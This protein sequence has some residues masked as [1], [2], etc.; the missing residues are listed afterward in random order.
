[1][2]YLEYSFLATA[3]NLADNS[4]SGPIQN[5]IGK[6][7][8]TNFNE[9][10]DYSYANNGSY[11]KNSRITAYR[12]GMLIW[13]TEPATVNTVQ[14]LKISTENKS[15]T[16]TNSIS[17]YLQLNNVGN[18]PVNYSDLKVRYYF[19]SDGTPSLNFYLDY[20]ML[21]NSNVKGQFIKINPPLANADT[22]LEITFPNLSKLYPLS[23]IGN[24]QYR[25]AK[26]DWSNFNQSNDYSYHNGSSPMSEN[27]RVVVYL[28]SQRVYGTEPGAGAR[29]GTELTEPN[30]SVTVL[31][32]PVRGTELAVEVRGAE[33]QPLRFQLTDLQGKVVS[34]RLL[35]VAGSV[36]QQRLVVSEGVNG[37]LLL[38][39]STPI[40][41]QIVKVL[42]E[43]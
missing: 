1:M 15:S 22:Y 10:D 12:N 6:Q 30:L 43:K 11:T 32:N 16:T 42:L 38:Q 36:E 37:L 23:G 27:N 31:G 21:G 13:G 20:A 2:G 4:N 3:G 17:T 14:S 39:V 19:T 34:E 28:A 18:V 24:I 35:E 9:A 5:G 7:D 8:W 33:S 41:R 29:V 40:Q 26:Q 25:I